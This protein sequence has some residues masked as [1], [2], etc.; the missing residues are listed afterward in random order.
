MICRPDLTLALALCKACG[1]ADYEEMT[2]IVLNIFDSRKGVIKFLKAAIEKEVHDTGTSVLRLAPFGSLSDS[3]SSEHE[4]TVFRGNSFTTRLLTVF[5]RAKGYDYLRNT[6]ANLLLGLS[7]KPSEFSMDFDP[8]RA[9][10]DDDEAARNLEQ[11]TEAFL[12]VIAVSWKKLP[13]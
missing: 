7:N 1:S 13:R 9:T 12:N 2:E 4:S 10:A 5:A 11:V 6:L 8:H 3:I